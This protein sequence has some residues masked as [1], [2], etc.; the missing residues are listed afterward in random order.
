MTNFSDFV[1]VSGR[2]NADKQTQESTKQDQ[3]LNCSPNYLV[4]T[5]NEDKGM[6]LLP[7]TTQHALTLQKHV[8]RRTNTCE[9]TQ[10]KDSVCHWRILSALRLGRKIDL[11]VVLQ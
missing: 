2:Q 5:C 8:M 1:L 3:T 10:G 6:E 4:Q 7:W 11:A 9:R